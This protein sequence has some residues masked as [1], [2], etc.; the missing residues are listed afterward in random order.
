MDGF[1][2]VLNLS[3]DGVPEAASWSVRPAQ[4]EVSGNRAESLTLIISTTG[5][6]A[7]NAG[8]PPGTYPIILTATSGNLSH[9][10]ALTLIVR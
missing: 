7:P 9:S 3:C 2:G 5:S 10:L 8:T 1:A 4:P 6:K